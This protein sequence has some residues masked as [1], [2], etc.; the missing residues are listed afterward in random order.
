[1]G[2]LESALGAIALGTG[3]SSDEVAE[4]GKR[5]AAVEAENA[6]L[7]SVLRGEKAISGAFGKTRLWGALNTVFDTTATEDELEQV[8]RLLNANSKEICAALDAAMA[9]GDG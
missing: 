4:I 3:M 6:E 7:K 8:M 9:K 2:S 1:M 5:L